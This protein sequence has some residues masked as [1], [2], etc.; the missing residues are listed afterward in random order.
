MS[1]LSALKPL[2]RP[3]LWLAAWWFGVAAV[4][5]LSL[6]P[7]FLL[8]QVPDGGDK[9]EHFLS[10]FLLAAAAVQL[11]LPRQA[12]LRAGSGL[13]AM[14]IALEIAQGLFTSTRQMDATDALANSLGVAAGLLTLLTPWCNALLHVDR[15]PDR[16]D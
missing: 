6:V 13:I 5:A 12:V 11:F 14:G 10:Y 7:A 2:R 15:R 1:R 8:P 4:V 16:I 3:R 9:L